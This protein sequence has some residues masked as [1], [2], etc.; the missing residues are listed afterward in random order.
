M[1]RRPVF[2]EKRSYRHRRMMDALR[3]LPFLG[4]ALWMMP[5]LWPMPGETGEGMPMST[6]LRYLFGVWAGLIL[7]CWALWR[8]TAPGPRENAAEAD[9]TPP[10]AG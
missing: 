5:L 10:G 7:L 9:G 8:R 1:S 3:L 2:L 4:V 6:A